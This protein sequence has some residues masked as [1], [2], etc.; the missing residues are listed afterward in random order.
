LTLLPSPSFRGKPDT[1][2]NDAITEIIK[3]IETGKRQIDP[4]NLSD[5]RLQGVAL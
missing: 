1:P 4:E 5:S 3:E 2:F